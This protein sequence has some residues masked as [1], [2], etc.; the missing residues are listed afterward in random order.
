MAIY[1][2]FDT[3]EQVQ[4]ATISGWGS[5]GDWVDGLSVD[6]A[7]ELIHVREYGWSQEIGDLSEQLRQSMSAAPPPDDDTASIANGLAD[8]LATSGD[9]EVLIVSDGLTTNLP[10]ERTPLEKVAEQLAVSTEQLV[11]AQTKQAS[12]GPA[13]PPIIENHIHLPPKTNATVKRDKDGR[14]SEI[15]HEGDHAKPKPK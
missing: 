6:D 1:G 9:A 2:N 10:V 15:I 5:F 12:A 3:G 7:P 14:I 11:I 13:A 4:L 8:F